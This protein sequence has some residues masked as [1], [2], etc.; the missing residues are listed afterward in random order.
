M[1][2]N[3]PLLKDIHLPPEVST[4]PLGYGWF[5]II[6]LFLTMFLIYKA[7]KALYLQSKKYYALKLLAAQKDDNLQTVKKASELLR[8]ICKVKFPKAVG[9]AGKDWIDFLNAHAKTPLEGKPAELLLYAPYMQ[10]NQDFTATDFNQVRL[11][12]QKWIGENL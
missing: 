11:F 2:E 8:R 9:F 5:L 6:G 3:L 7:G 12:I 10:Q 4:F 1:E